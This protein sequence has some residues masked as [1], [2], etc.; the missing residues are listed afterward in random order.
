MEFCFKRVILR[1]TFYLPRACLTGGTLNFKCNYKNNRKS[2]IASQKH[3]LPKEI[4]NFKYI[5]FDGHILYDDR[6]CLI[7]IR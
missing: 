2:S 3:V 7:N 4:D 1:K 6:T 5:R